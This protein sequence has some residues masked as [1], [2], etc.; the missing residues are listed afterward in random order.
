MELCSSGIN[1]GHEQTASINPQTNHRFDFT[2]ESYRRKGGSF[3]CTGLSTEF[4]ILV[5]QPVTAL[6]LT[7]CI[8]RIS[9]I[10]S[11]LR[12]VVYYSNSLRR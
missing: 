8:F 10:S 9:S 5:S 2:L 7:F 11:F 1:G 6:H 12:I 3:S 4:G